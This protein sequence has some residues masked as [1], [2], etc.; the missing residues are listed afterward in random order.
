MEKQ[1]TKD[2]ETILWNNT[3]PGIEATVAL[4]R[5]VVKNLAETGLIFASIK[6]QKNKTY[7]KVVS[8]L[9]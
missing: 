6:L 4:V 7:R 1:Q 5:P 2:I 8:H 9:L 3:K